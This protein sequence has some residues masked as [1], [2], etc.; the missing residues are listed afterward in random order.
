MDDEIWVPLIVAAI[1]VMTSIVTLVAMRFLDRRI[2]NTR[3]LPKII[4]AGIFP[5]LLIVAILAVWHYF[6]YQAYLRGPQEGWMGPLL[7]LI[8][9]FPYFVMNILCNLM[10]VGYFSRHDK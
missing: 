3:T 5:S 10:V 9:G 8:Y 7:F 6:E 2:P 1:I 4:A